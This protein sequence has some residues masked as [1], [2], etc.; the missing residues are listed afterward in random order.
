MSARVS[1][2]DSSRPGFRRAKSDPIYSNTPNPTSVGCL[3]LDSLRALP[4]SILVKL[5]CRPFRDPLLRAMSLSPKVSK[6]FF[7]PKPL[8]LLS[9]NSSTPV[10]SLAA[11]PAG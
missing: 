2:S 5:Y 1:A 11:P 10:F 6:D 4:P 7:I 8:V 9:A 3:A